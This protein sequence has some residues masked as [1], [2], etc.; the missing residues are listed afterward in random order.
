MVA[1]IGGSRRALPYAFVNTICPPWTMP[2]DAL[3]TPVFVRISC[4]AASTFDCWSAL[5]DPCA[6]SGLEVVSRHAAVTISF[7]SFMF[8]LRPVS[9]LRNPASRCVT[10]GRRRA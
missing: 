7:D 10:P 3:G 8:L 6:S 4:T 5:S 2:T 1:F 9:S